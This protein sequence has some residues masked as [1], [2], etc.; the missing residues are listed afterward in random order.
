MYKRQV[1]DIPFPPGADSMG[2]TAFGPQ[3]AGGLEDDTEQKSS[4]RFEG[5]RDVSVG[6]EYK[7]QG[8]KVS[9]IGI[10]SLAINAQDVKIEGNAIELI[11]D[12]EIIQQANWITSFLNSGR[13]EFIALFNPTSSSLTGQFSMVKGAI[14][15]I[16]TDLPFP[17]IAPPAQVRITVG[18]TM[19]GSMADVLTGSQNCFHATFI[20]APTGVI[21]EFV[22]QGAIINQCNNGMGAYVVNSGYLAV[23]CSAGPCQGFGLPILLN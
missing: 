17:A 21:A 19:P 6:G 1:D 13:F 16:T 7:V 22:P 2:R 23:G 5:D 18:Q 8:A 9:Y 3:L 10:E 15:D 4:A 11:A 12:G 20:T 14:V